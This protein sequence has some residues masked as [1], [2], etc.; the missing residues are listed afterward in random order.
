M[1]YDPELA[2]IV[3]AKYLDGISVDDITNYIVFFTEYHTVRN[4]DVNEIID[5]L[6]EVL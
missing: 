2:R 4:D 3:Y 5:F 6:N 1:N